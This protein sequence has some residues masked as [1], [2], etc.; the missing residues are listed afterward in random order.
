VSKA[1]G[2]SL[3]NVHV[4]A[5]VPAIFQ[6]MV[7]GLVPRLAGGRP[8]GTVS[9]RAMVPEGELAG[10]LAE[11]AAGHPAVSIGCYPFED[12]GRLGANLVLRSEDEAALA[13]AERALGAMLARLDAA[14]T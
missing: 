2:F 13:E 14:R 5:G 9:A 3:G 10:P 1:P 7:A 4:M 8:L 6:A 12:D 11:L